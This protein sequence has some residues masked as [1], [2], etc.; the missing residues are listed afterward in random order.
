MKKRCI[1]CWMIILSLLCCAPGLAEYAILPENI[2]EIAA[3]YEPGPYGGVSL[4][5]QTPFS[6]ILLSPDD[7][8]QRI[9]K[10][11]SADAVVSYIRKI[12]LPLDPLDGEYFYHYRS[13]VRQEDFSL[14]HG[15]MLTVVTYAYS[16]EDNDNYA[17]LFLLEEGKY[18]LVD[19]IPHFGQIDL[20]SYSGHI[21]LVG[22]TGSSYQT[23]RWYHLQGRKMVLRY[24]SQGVMPD[25]PDYHIAVKSDEWPQFQTRFEQDGRLILLKQLSVWDYT[26]SPLSEDAREIILF[27]QIFIYSAQEDGTFLL[28]AT[29]EYA[30]ETLEQVLNK[31]IEVF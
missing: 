20:V 1:L 24:L 31:R 2:E 8:T 11:Q 26:Q 13:S 4:Q 6:P 5:E 3:E 7:F 28:E 21:Y 19:C 10:A 27:T 12:G 16:E 15:S 29:E 17:L 14:P 23:T 9:Q 22:K 18:T 25:R 30:L